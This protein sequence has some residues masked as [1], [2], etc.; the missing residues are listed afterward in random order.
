[1]KAHPTALVDPGAQVADDVEIGPFCVIGPGVRIAAGCR[2]GPRVSIH[3]PATLGLNNILHAKVAVGSPEGGPVEIGDGNV[4]RE[5]THISSPGPKGL[6]KL[7]SRCRFGVWVSLGPAST[8]GDDAV[9][10]AFAV[11][12]ENGSV[13]SGARIEGQTVIEPGMK[14]GRRARVR[15]QVPVIGDVPE[16]VLLDGNPAEIRDAGGRS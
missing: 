11:L 10:G 4:L 9:F 2:L 1:M 16:D 5:S 3:G 7:G 8:V 12:A 6:T 14:I 13:E 15:S